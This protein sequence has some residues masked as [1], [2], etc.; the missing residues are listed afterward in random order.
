MQ[1]FCFC[2]C[3]RGAQAQTMT[4]GGVVC[5]KDHAVIPG[6]SVFDKDNPDNLTTSGPDGAYTITVL[7]GARLEFSYMGFR[8]QLVD[9]AGRAGIDVIMQEDSFLQNEIAKT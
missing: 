1:P 5:D 8:T 7:P 3:P 2:F 6:V 4:V 9:V